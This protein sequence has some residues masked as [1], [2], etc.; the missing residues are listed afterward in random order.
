MDGMGWD[1]R[2]MEGQLRERERAR[3]HTNNT[4]GR[5]VSVGMQSRNE[6][7]SGNGGWYEYAVL[8]SIR[9]LLGMAMLDL[10]QIPKGESGRYHLGCWRRLSSGHGTGCSAGLETSA[11]DFRDSACPRALLQSQPCKA[12]LA[13]TALVIV[14][15]D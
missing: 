2:T 6:S 5:Y 14:N 13:Y 1:V 4:V 15:T 3:A 8:F 12:L 11:S 10:V 7:D 9:R